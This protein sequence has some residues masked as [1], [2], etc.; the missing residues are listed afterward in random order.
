VPT[1]PQP[2][3][4]TTIEDLA[5]IAAKIQPITRSAAP[6]NRRRIE[7]IFNSYGITF[8]DAPTTNGETPCR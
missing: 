5:A 4:T 1:T 6:T 3:A 8:N 2:C 7:A